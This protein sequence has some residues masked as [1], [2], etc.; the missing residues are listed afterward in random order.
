[1]SI[2]KIRDDITVAIILASAGIIILLWK[3]YYIWAVTAFV[4]L[5]IFFYASYRFQDLGTYAGLLALVPTSLVGGDYVHTHLTEK[6]LKNILKGMNIPVRSLKMLPDVGKYYKERYHFT[7]PVAVKVTT[8]DN[9]VIRGYFDTKQ[10][11]FV[12]DNPQKLPVY[13]DQLIDVWKLINRVH[14]NGT[15]RKI[16]S[17]DRNDKTV[18][19]EVFNERGS[20]IEGWRVRKGVREVWNLE[21]KEW[22]PQSEFRPRVDDL[23]NG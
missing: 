11:F 23:H 3:E 18:S 16:E 1:M 22:V 14:K 6:N 8:Q 13:S 4:T 20:L 7:N 9:S 15:P 10:D 5:I 21:K 12:I 19:Q 2:F 17:K